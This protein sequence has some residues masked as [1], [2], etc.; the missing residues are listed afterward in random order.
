LDPTKVV[1]ASGPLSDGGVLALDPRTVVVASG[2]LSGAG[3]LALD[4]MDAVVARGPLPDDFSVTIDGLSPGATTAPNRCVCAGVGA[5]VEPWI[6]ARAD[7]GPA[8]D[9]SPEPRTVVGA[10]GR[11]VPANAGSVPVVVIASA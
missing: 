9:V 1:V 3:L 5:T 11:G 7:G 10:G 8:G 4:P 6:V 2:P